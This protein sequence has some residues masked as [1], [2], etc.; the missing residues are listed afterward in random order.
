MRSPA[1]QCPVM[2]PSC[3]PTIPPEILM[4]IGLVTTVWGWPRIKGT[5]GAFSTYEKITLDL[6]SS[7]PRDNAFNTS[8]REVWV[9]SSGSGGGGG[10]GGHAP[11]PPPP[12]K[13]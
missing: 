3:E 8:E 1:Y 5:G 6:K 12:C 7:R 10:Q 11:P 4:E 9:G 13:K 2:P